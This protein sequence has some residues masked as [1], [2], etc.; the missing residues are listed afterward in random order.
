MFLLYS[1]K[2]VTNIFFFTRSTVDRYL[3]YFQFGAVINSAVM[4][5]LVHLF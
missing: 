3:I 4:N 5:I 1:P 2:N